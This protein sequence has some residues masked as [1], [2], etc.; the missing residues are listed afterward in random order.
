MDENQKLYTLFCKIETVLYNY[1]VAKDLRRQNKRTWSMTAYY[2]TLLHC[3]RTI[4]YMSVEDFP[5]QHD[6]FAK[7]LIGQPCG[8]ITSWLN[9]TSN[10]G[11]RFAL[12]LNNIIESLNSK[13]GKSEEDIT[14]NLEDL[15]A[16][17]SGTKRM[18]EMSNYEAFIMA[19]QTAHISVT[20]SLNKG[21]SNIESIVKKEVKVLLEYYIDFIN[22]LNGD[23]K[24]TYIEFLK[25]TTPRFAAIKYLDNMLDESKIDKN[26][27]KE[28]MDLING[29]LPKLV[30]DN[31]YDNHLEDFFDSITLEH[32]FEKNE[33]MRKLRE[34]IDAL[35]NI[36]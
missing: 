23:V 17:L 5:T 15:G 2:Y 10:H 4:C 20:P 35:A 22:T 11:V 29:I 33:K 21:L 6:G 8:R 27:R 36:G 16:E 3:A 13:T 24:N 19:H 32:F 30:Y 1:A 34:D 31:N 28:V 7:F 25:N 9:S 18:R 26:I 12:S 14:R